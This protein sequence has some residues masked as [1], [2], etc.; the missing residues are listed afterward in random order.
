MKKLRRFILCLLIVVLVCCGGTVNILTYVSDLIG[1]ASN[2]KNEIFVT[3]NIVVEGLKDEKDIEFLRQN[4]NS[5]SDEQV[6]KYNYSDSLSFNIKI[7]IINSNKIASHNFNNDLLYIIASEKNNKYNFVYQFNKYLV[8]SI[9]T[10]VYNTH[11]QHVNFGDFMVSFSIDN[12][13]QNNIRL[14]AYS[15]YVKGDPYPSEY[16]Q[17]LK[18]RDRIELR[19]SEIFR[20]AV[21]KNNN[22]QYLLFSIDK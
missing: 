5:F 20:A 3:A 10:Y 17:E 16:I 21:I 4:L 2:V 11:Y 15:V 6:I 14:T 1:V 22:N 7:P 19:V 12:D 13:M 18:R 8:N 9:D